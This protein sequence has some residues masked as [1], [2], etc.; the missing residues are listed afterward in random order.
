VG[1]VAGVDDQRRLLRQRVEEVD[2]PVERCADVG[3]GLLVE[4]DVR[5]AD[6]Y[7][8]R[9]AERA[10]AFGVGGGLRECHGGEHAAGERE[11]RPGAAE[12]HAR[13][14][15]A[16]RYLGTLVRHVGTPRFVYQGD[17]AD[18]GFIPAQRASRVPRSAMS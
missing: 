9:L 13:E 14:R 4:A 5:V 2:A 6:L 8:E 3:V 15:L 1:D 11:Q 17:S 7:E 18:A 12:G 10:G 16:A